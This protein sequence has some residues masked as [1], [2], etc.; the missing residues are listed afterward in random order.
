M[1]SRGYLQNNYVQSVSFAGRQ[2]VPDS[3]IVILTRILI[4]GF[5]MHRGGS[6]GILK[7]EDNMINLHSLIKGTIHLLYTRQLICRCFGDA[8]L[9]N[10]SI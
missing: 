1:A 7:K 10:F 9:H 2:P 6:W 5:I 3:D 4:R 8:L